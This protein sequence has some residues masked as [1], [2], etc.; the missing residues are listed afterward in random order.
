MRHYS[1]RAIQ[2]GEE[3]TLHYGDDNAANFQ[4]D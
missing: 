4:K 2:A 1:T 3:I